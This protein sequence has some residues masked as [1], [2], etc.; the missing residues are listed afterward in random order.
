MKEIPQLDLT[1][2]DMLYVWL[3]RRGMT[4]AQ[5]ARAMKVG[6]TTVARWMKAASIPEKRHEK[7]VK[8]GIPAE[9]LPP[10]LDIAPGPKKKA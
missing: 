3:K 4:Q 6:E 7:L 9:L 2:Q 5:I 8:L 1:R 10:P